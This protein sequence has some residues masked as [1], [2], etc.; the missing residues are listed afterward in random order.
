MRRMLNRLYETAL[1]WVFPVLC[2][3]CEAPLSPY[4]PSGV[5]TSCEAQ[6]H[7]IR[8]PVC[9]SCG[10]GVHEGV[11]TCARCAHEHFHFDR[12]FACAIYEGKIKELLHRFKFNERKY[13]K[14]FLGS[15]MAALLRGNLAEGR[16]DTVIPVPMDNQKR[17]ERGFNQSELLSR[18]VA[19]ELELPH[20]PR[21]LRRTAGS[22]PQHFLTKKDRERN[23]RGA[24]TARANGNSLDGKNVLLVDD[25]LTTGQTASE[26][27]RALKEAGAA[28]V[29]VLALARGV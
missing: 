13:L 3:L 16:F 8:P 7:W 19:Q 23:A 1:S 21:R 6:I 29:T 15:R 4:P 10:R 12:A 27:A 24:F 20:D 26:C 25:I 18:R 11:L 2:E 17:N 28:S 9:V 22:R 5:C 14:N